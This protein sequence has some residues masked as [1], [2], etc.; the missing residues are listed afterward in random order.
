MI[1][2]GIRSGSSDHL[3]WKHIIPIF[4]NDTTVAAK[5]IL[6][7]GAVSIRNMI[8]ETWRVQGVRDLLDSDKKRHEFKSSHCF[9]KVL[10]LNLR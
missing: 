1:S 5:I 10:K 2:A 7:N 8:G 9:R 3:K 6:N 4:R